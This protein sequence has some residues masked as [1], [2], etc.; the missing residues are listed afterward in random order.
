LHIAAPC[1]IC[2]C[3]GLWHFQQ[4]GVY[5]QRLSTGRRA[6]NKK[7]GV[8]NEAV[9]GQLSAPLWNFFPQTEKF[10]KTWSEWPVMCRGLK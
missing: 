5:V 6:T 8:N 4:L 3:G 1:S 2:V 10:I 9:F 7:W